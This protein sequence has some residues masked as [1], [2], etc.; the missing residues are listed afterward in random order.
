MGARTPPSLQ[1][2]RVKKRV[3]VSASALG[4]GVAEF[5]KKNGCGSGNPTRRRYG[6]LTGMYVG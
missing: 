2:A 6:L 3:A 1:V 4:H 5:Y